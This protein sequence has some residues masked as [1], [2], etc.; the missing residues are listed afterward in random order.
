MLASGVDGN[1]FDGVGLGEG[2]GEIVEQVASSGVAVGLEENVNVP[3]ATLAGG[4]KGGA[5]FRRVVAIIVDDGD[6]V[7][8]A[9][10]LK[11]AVDATKAAEA[12]SYLV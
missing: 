10:V 2:G 4:G 1:E 7:S 12:F 8:G 6:A 11:A 5:D 3:I 9:L